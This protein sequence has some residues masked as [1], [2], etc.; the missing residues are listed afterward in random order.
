MRNKQLKLL[1]LCAIFKYTCIMYNQHIPL[2]DSAPKV[3]PQG[4][5]QL[6]LLQ[7]W[8][9]GLLVLPVRSKQWLL[10]H[11][12]QYIYIHTSSLWWSGGTVCWLSGLST[13]ACIRNKAEETVGKFIILL[14]QYYM[15]TIYTYVKI[16]AS[17]KF[18]PFC[19]LFSLVKI[20]SC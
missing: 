20:L 9:A 19:H 2:T 7:S 15:Y 10:N 6:L 11:T 12:L 5:L 8:S 13:L 16:F 18:S 3:V 17:T 1:L 4:Q 14:W